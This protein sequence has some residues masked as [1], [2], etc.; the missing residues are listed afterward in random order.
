MTKLVFVTSLVLSRWQK[1]QMR[2]VSWALFLG[3][4]VSF[5]MNVAKAN[6]ESVATYLCKQISGQ[7]NYP[8]KFQSDDMAPYKSLTNYDGQGAYRSKSKCTVDQSGKTTELEFSS[9][10]DL[11]SFYPGN[12][13]WLEDSGS[14]Q[15]ILKALKSGTD[16]LDKLYSDVDPQ[17]D[18]FKVRKASVRL[19]QQPGTDKITVTLKWWQNFSDGYESKTLGEGESGNVCI[20]A[21][22]IKYCSDKEYN[23]NHDP[24][25]PKLYLA[26]T[27]TAIAEYELTFENIVWAKTS[28]VGPNLLEGVGPQLHSTFRRIARYYRRRWS[29]Y[30]NPYISVSFETIPDNEKYKDISQCL[31]GGEFLKIEDLKPAVYEGAKD[32]RG[33]SF[34]FYDYFIGSRPGPREAYVYSGDPCNI[35]VSS[36]LNSSGDTSSS[37]FP[38]QYFWNEFWFSRP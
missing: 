10:Y 22:G 3:L 20:E 14:S 12:H 6:T 17:I 8:I 1:E 24:E 35:G 36:L 26:M 16:D 27:A 28:N 29:G 34:G 37:P 11:Y 18:D 32:L 23:S 7:S 33:L 4:L 31:S 2:L 21:F 30:T 38:P 15:N 25:K 19:Y 5:S 9:D 13:Y